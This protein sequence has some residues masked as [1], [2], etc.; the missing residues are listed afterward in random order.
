MVASVGSSAVFFL[1]TW[2][3]R[4]AQP[5][6]RTQGELGLQFM[7]EIDFIDSQKGAYSKL[8]YGPQGTHM[9]GN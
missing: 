7:I 8:T 3:L 1:G 4:F 9:K 2:A 6:S 5:R